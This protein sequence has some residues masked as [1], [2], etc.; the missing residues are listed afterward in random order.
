MLG[1]DRFEDDI[2]DPQHGTGDLLGEHH[3]ALADLDRG[4]LQRG[5]PIGEAAPCRRVVVEALG[6]HQVLHGDAPADAPADVH[7]IGGETRTARKVHRVAVAATDGHVGQR[8]RRGL[9]NA[10]GYRSDVLDR[11][12]R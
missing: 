5:N 3:E 1:V 9:A 7:G 4:E 6:V 2:V 8:Q 10:F 11:P 12:A